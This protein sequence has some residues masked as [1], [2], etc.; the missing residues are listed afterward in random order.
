MCSKKFRKSQKNQFQFSAMF[1]NQLKK[2]ATK[3]IN[4]PSIRQ[5]VICS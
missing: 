4:Q 3:N 1:Q 5:I 2:Y